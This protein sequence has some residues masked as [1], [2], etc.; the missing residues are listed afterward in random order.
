MESSET[1]AQAACAALMPDSALA[2]LLPGF[3]ARPQQQQMSEAVAGA[4]DRGETVLL[5][6]G[7]GTGKTMAYLLPALMS[8]KRTVI[9]TATK[10]LQDQLYRQDLP[11]ALEALGLPRRTALLKGRDNYL[12]RYRLDRAAEQASGSDAEQILS[13]RSFMEASRSGELSDYAGL[14]DASPL[15]PRVTSTADNCLGSRCPDFDDCFVFR[16]RRRALDADVVIVNHH[17]LFADFAVRE[18]GFSEIL[19]GAEVVIVDEAHQMPELAANAFGERLSTRQL[20]ELLRDLMQWHGLAD[21]PALLDETRTLSG[22]L[23]LLEDDCGQLAPRLSRDDFMSRPGIADLLQSLDVGLR[24]LGDHLA[25]QED[26]DEEGARLAERCR[27]AAGR[28][29]RFCSPSD[30]ETSSIP[31]R[32]VE[33]LRSRG[34]VLCNC[35]ADVSALYQRAVSGHPGAWIYVSATLSVDGDFSLFRSQLGIDETATSLL[36]PQ[37]FDYAA[38][39][40]LWIP[41]GVPDPKAGEDRHT[42]ALLD[43]ILPVLEAAEGGA[44]LLMTTHRAVQR[45]AQWLSARGGFELFVQG[46]DDRARL[47]DG[48][49]RSERGVLIGAASFWEGVDVPG[50]ALR[51]VVIDKLPFAPP[52]D[53]LVAA[54]I[55]RLREHGGDPFRDYQLPQAILT[56]RQGVGRLIRGEKDRGLLVL[57]DARIRSRGYGRKV[58]RALPPMTGIDDIDDAVAYARSLHPEAAAWLDTGDDAR[59]QA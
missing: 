8:G 16:A 33:T 52:N 56:L 9:S 21:L 13:L 32:W 49:A 25:G 55:A 53:P 37:V 39:A 51:I 59:V 42:A 14:S 45:A 23:A 3:R 6:A 35:P 24:A 2:G 47:L 19:P 27:D 48:F 58:L 38:Q 17:L 7:T 4:V 22:Q 5:E 12:C 28:L 34:G 44:F 20:A 46:D 36:L 1:L 30:D 41:Q 15:R 31:V 29:R 40:R 10:N 26:G 11:R 54:R 57:G 50:A 43:G 18:A